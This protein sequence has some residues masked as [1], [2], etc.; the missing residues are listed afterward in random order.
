M[1]TMRPLA[2]L[3]VILGAFLQ[4]A[5]RTEPSKKQDLH[6][7]ISPMQSQVKVGSDIQLE[8]TLKNISKSPVLAS[9]SARLH[10]FTYLEV[11]DEHG[12]TVGWKGK[13]ASKSYSP[14]TFV[15]LKPGQS[16]SFQAVISSSTDGYEMQEPGT[17]RVRAEF[18]IS[19]KEYFAPVAQGSRIP[20]Q[21]SHSNWVTITV[22]PAEP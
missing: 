9:R 15:V 18:S 5:A 11:V 17:Y 14:D 1:N 20:E 21:P 13:I 19:P 12:K 8:L 10:D 2:I 3:S 22:S 16:I 7:S 6:L 4:I